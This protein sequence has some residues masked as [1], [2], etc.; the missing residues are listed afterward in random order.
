MAPLASATQKPHAGCPAD[1]EDAF[2]LEL[3]SVFRWLGLYD[4]VMKEYTFELSDH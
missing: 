2:V 1:N 3:R 4:F